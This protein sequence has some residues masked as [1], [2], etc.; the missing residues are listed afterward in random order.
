M[1][2]FGMQ[3]MAG[4]VCLMLLLLPLLAV[5]RAPV[6]GETLDSDYGANVA[7]AVGV[8]KTAQLGFGW[9]RIYYPEQVADA[10]RHGLKALLLLG[11]DSSLR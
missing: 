10:E 2:R 7:T 6:R 4:R 3:A 1:N 8:A 9:V 5:S 11:W